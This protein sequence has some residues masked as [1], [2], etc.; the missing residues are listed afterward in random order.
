[1]ALRKDKT[2]AELDERSEA[3]GGHT[4]KA[5]KPKKIHST[6]IHHVGG[7]HVVHHF[8]QPH[9]ANM[10]P[11]ITQVIPHGEAGEGDIEPLAAH[12]EGHLGAPN[13]GE[14]ELA[15]GVSPEP[16]NAHNLNAN[17]A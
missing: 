10:K 1:M 13:A 11:D 12:L 17:L 4:P 15:T 6:L 9:E 2:M 16:T 7:G 8:H 3:L 5:P 14:S